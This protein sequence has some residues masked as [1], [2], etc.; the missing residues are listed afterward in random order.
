MG[1]IESKKLSAE[2]CWSRKR[3]SLVGV[4][5]AYRLIMKGRFSCKD[6][7]MVGLAEEETCRVVSCLWSMSQK[8]CSAAG[9]RMSKRVEIF[10][11]RA[12]DM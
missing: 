4:G 12:Q 1:V 8:S 2:A 5:L 10:E 11:I 7:A 3:S 6:I 9:E